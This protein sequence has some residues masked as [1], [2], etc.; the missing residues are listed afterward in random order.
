MDAQQK[1]IAEIKQIRYGEEMKD[2]FWITDMQPNMIMHP[3]R[4]D[5]DG[6]SLN[7][8]KDPHGKRLFV[9]F[10]NVVKKDEQGYVDYMWQWKDD[11]LRIVP[12]LSYVKL[13]KPWGWIIGTGIYIED[14]KKEIKALT[15]KLIWISIGISVLIALL[16]LFISQQSLKNRT[17]THRSRK[18]TARVERKI[19]NPG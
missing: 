3:Y 15:Q 16:L 18:R 2:Y 6:K 14:V 7:D 4:S 5:L 13:F 19:P 10:V 17:Q 1:A 12:K 9:E 8:F 11:S